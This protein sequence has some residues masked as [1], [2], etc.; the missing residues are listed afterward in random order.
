[1]NTKEKGNLGEM[2][3]MTEFTKMGYNIS[4]PLGD[5]HSYDF[6][7]EK[8]GKCFK[9]QCKYTDSKNGIIKVRCGSTVTK[10][11]GG[12]NEFRR[13][14][15]DNVDI[16]VIYDSMT[17]KCY[18]ISPENFKTILQLR[19]RPARNGQQKLINHAENY[20]LVAQSV[21]QLLGKE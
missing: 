12:K 5:N 19:T 14:N 8:D 2:L 3:V 16:L 9:V 20:A 7:A 10:L 11:K 4:V 21:E 6:I 1:M 17:N 13:Y 15:S 18:C